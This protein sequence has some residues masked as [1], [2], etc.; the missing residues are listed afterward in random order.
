MQQGLQSCEGCG[1]LS[2]PAPGAR[3]RALPA[4][5]RGAR[6]PQAR[7]RAA[8]LGLPD[9]RRDLLRPGQPPAGADDDHGR[10]RRFRHDPPGR[11]AALV[12]DRMAAVPHRADREHHDPERARSWRSAY[13]LVTRAAR[14]R[15][16]TTSSASASTGWSQLI[17]RWSMVDVFVDTFTAALVQLQPLMS[18]QPAPGLLF[19]AAVVVLDHA[20]GRVLR[21]AAD[22]GRRSSASEVAP[23]LTADRPARS[24][25]RGRRPEAD[26]ALRSSGSSRSSPPLAG[27]WVAVTRILSEGP[28]ITIV[29]HSAE[30]LEAGKTKIHYNGV[31]VGTLTT[32]RLSDDHQQRDRHRAD[33]AEDRGLPGRRHA[34]LGRAPAHLG[35]QRD[36]AG[37]AHLRRLHRHGDRR[38]EGRSSATSWRST[39][40]PVVTG[41]VAGPLLRAEDARPRLA[42][43][44]HA[45]LLPAA[46]GRARSRRTRSTRT[47]RR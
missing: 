43:H 2:R 24:P 6:V 14:A 10:R 37:H 30:G 28:K 42:R 23:C 31:D 25:S 7:Q 29:F 8:D 33:G 9:R 41:D 38:L 13:L 44:R 18:V 26:A 12:A 45:D 3:R 4:L 39:T 17:G 22:L 35:R 5:R 11:R 47:A 27:A 32:I 36:R 40:P 34:V 15:S 16:R 19:F 21:S 20:R 46:P 1:L